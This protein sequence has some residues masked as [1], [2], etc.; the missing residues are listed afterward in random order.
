MISHEFTDHMHKPTLL[1]LPPSIPVYATSKAY[2]AIKSWKHFSVVREIGRFD[3]DWRSTNPEADGKEKSILPEW[4]GVS[5]VAYAGTDLLY[6]HSAIM[7]CLPAPSTTG[8]GEAGV[9]EGN[10]QEAEAILY[11]PHG[12]TPQN[13]SPLI[14]AIPP[15]R[16]LALI[17]GLQDISLN[18]ITKAQLNLG[19]HNGLKVQ[20]MLGA[21]YWIGTHDEVK[22]GGGVVSWFLDRKAIGLEEAVAKAKREGGLKGELEGVRFVDVGNGEQLVLE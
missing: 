3:G 16:T 6:Y 17:H 18:T 22:K 15:I 11:T 19:A 9:A 5:R 13:I 14:S 4:V 12:V 1:S 2:T 21:K 20:R 7:I 8:Q 10:G